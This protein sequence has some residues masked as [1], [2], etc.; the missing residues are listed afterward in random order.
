[1]IKTLNKAIAY[2]LWLAFSGILT[3]FLVTFYFSKEIQGVYFTITSLIAIKAILDS[4]FSNVI[5]SYV[6]LNKNKIID[7]NKITFKDDGF[8]NISNIFLYSKK[9]F[10]VVS[11][12]G[13]L[14]LQI[15]G[16]WFFI[17]YIITENIFY[18]IT[19]TLIFSGNLLMIPY[20]SVI[21]G[22]DYLDSLFSFRLKCAFINSLS[23]WVVIFLGGGILCIIALNFSMLIQNFIY[24]RKYN[25]LFN[26]LNNGIYDKDFIRP[27]VK[28]MSIKISLSWASS[29]FTSNGLIP[30]LFKYINPVVAGQFGLSWALLSVISTV[31]KQFVIVNRPKLG[32]LY[33][34]KKFKEFS[35]LFIKNFLKGLGL[36]LILTIILF[37]FYNNL[38]SLE[39]IKR[40][41]PYN[42]LLLLSILFLTTIIMGYF[43]HFFRAQF[44]EPLYFSY[45]LISITLLISMILNINSLSVNLVMYTLIVANIIFGFTVLIYNLILFYKKLI[46]KK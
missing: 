15:L 42:Q 3:A 17:D 29:Y 40:L 41:L 2:N 27:I 11:V 1:M 43:T 12:L 4:G 28:P 21:E 32:S 26:K 44:K 45:V 20:F 22:L 23:S 6:A 37:F 24:L 13:F 30:F 25:R 14:S 18:W 31:S 10:K 38:G 5:L 33:N 35:S 36:F 34:E 7:K 46:I 16:W 9:R 8:K 19:L 39:I